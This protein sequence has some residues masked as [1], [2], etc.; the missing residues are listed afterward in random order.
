[1]GLEAARVALCG[2][3]GGQVVVPSSSLSLPSQRQSQLDMV[4]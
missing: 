3:H 1:M 2:G 4:R